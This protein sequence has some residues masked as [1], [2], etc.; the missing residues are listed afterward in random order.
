M[1][2]RWRNREER[3]PEAPGVLPTE[4]RPWSYR[5]AEKDDNA[6]RQSRV[7]ARYVVTG[8]DGE[9]YN[10]TELIMGRTVTLGRGENTVTVDRAVAKLA[11]MSGWVIDRTSPSAPR[12]GAY[13]VEYPR[14]RAEEPTDAVLITAEASGITRYEIKEVGG[15]MLI[16]SR[17]RH[18]DGD[19]R[20]E[21]PRGAR[22]TTTVRARIPAGEYPAKTPDEISYEE[23]FFEELRDAIADY[24]DEHPE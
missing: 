20:V 21:Q 15:Q 11:D 5:Y 4:G 17:E 23:R 9:D 10:V 8:G 6:E 22:I 7:E 19:T 18:V 13:L 16:V 3:T 2:K 12:T 14:A 1:L 24:N